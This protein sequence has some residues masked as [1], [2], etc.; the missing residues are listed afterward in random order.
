MGSG[1]LC[2]DCGIWVG[3]ETR[4][5]VTRKPKGSGEVF[6][7]YATDQ[8]SANLF[9]KGPDSILMFMAHTGS[10]MYFLLLLLL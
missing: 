5:P 4:G 6:A 9:C 7:L 8:G 10:V 2:A 3:E 1:L